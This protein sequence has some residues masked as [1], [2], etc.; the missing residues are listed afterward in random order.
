MFR[1]ALDGPAGL[2]TVTI[3]VDGVEA[4]AWEGETV[5][6]VLLRHP[7]VQRL[8]PVGGVRRAPFCQ[9]GVCFDCLAVVDGVASIQGCMVEVR[10]GMRIRRQEGARPVPTEQVS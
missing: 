6:S 7:N 3:F 2:P 9:M 10:Q 5:A 4:R 8:T 1:N